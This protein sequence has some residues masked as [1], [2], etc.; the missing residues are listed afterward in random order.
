[1][2]IQYNPDDYK[3]VVS[4]SLC[5]FHEKNPGK[6]YAGCSCSGNFTL[7]KKSPEELEKDRKEK[8]KIPTEISTFAILRHLSTVHADDPEWA[9][10]VSGKIAHEAML[11]IYN[12]KCPACDRKDVKIIQ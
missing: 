8:E 12:N 7:V 5:S 3:T 10:K 11:E 1:M 6:N 2:L 9:L 4:Q